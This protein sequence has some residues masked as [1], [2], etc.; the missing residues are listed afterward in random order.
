MSGSSIAD[1]PAPNATAAEILR[2]LAMIQ[3]SFDRSL[4]PSGSAA[5]A[6]GGD[7]AAERLLVSTR[8]TTPMGLAGLFLQHRH[9]DGGGR[10]VLVRWASTWWR[11]RDGFYRGLEDEDLRAALWAFLDKITVV[12]HDDDGTRHEPLVAR[13][14]MVAEVTEALMAEG[15]APRVTCHPPA[16]ISARADLDPEDLLVC[17][18]GIVHLPSRRLLPSDPDLF[19]PYGIDVPYR[20]DACAPTAWLRFLHDL[21][22]DEP[23]CIETLQTMMGYFLT[24]DTR[25][26]KIFLL[27]GPKRSGKGTIGRIIRAIIGARNIASPTLGDLERPFGL[28]SMI[29]RS[30]AI[31]GDA[32]LSGRADQAA[33]AER[34]LSV[35]GED[36][37]DVDRKHR[38]S[39]TMRLRTRI[40]LLSNEL[41]RLAD[42]SGALASRF[43]LVTM[44]RSFLGEEDLGLEARLLTELP[45]ILRW[46]VDGWHLLR[47]RGSFRQPDS[48]AEAITELEGLASP[49]SQFLDDCCEVDGRC[50][51]EVARLF[52][53]WQTWCKDAGRDHPGTRQSFG[54]D[55]RA[56]LPRLRTT[57]PRRPDG[58]RQRIYHGLG[59]R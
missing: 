55:L 9:H 44:K 13:R 56:L 47:A 31:I 41:P 6:S 20:E 37:I 48:S 8:E 25:Q 53:R 16:W 38:E 15:C 2:E 54:R 30:L 21:W 52:E 26:Q 49:I 59:L 23:D 19:T 10:P 33:I 1:P 32:R 3:A 50:E 4:A 34:L 5:M 18:N 35:S 17:P 24:P 12:V 57:Y 36:A 45:G 43:Q 51:V 7:A 28:Q 58:V 39:V 22:D 42:A 46:A 29:G 11:M 40:L 14:A 27:V